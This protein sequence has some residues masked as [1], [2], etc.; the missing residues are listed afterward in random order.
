MTASPSHSS[1][2]EKSSLH[3]LFST[4]LKAAFFCFIQVLFTLNAASKTLAQ[5][6]LPT[7]VIEGQVTNTDGKPIKGATVEWGYFMDE[8]EK[9]EVFRTDAN[10]KY[11]VE[12]TKVGPDFR[13]GASAAGFAPVWQ[14]GVI[15]PKL[16]AGKPL[17]IDFKLP[18]PN[19]LRGKV[20]DRDG[21]PIAGV[22]VVAQSPTS[23][24]MSSFSMSTP[25]YPFPGPARESTT[26]ADG[27]FL[28]RYL[29]TTSVIVDE[30]DKG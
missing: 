23:G 17:K 18:A 8:K 2:I 3:W 26:N 30:A 5:D 19:S 24:F 20:V 25:S 13:L 14:D 4:P 15:P 11:R 1:T 27:E 9:R 6:L 10:G 28:I 12:T 29:P 16:A 7:R 21:K 22:T